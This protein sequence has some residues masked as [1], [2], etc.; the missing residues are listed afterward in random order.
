[1]LLKSKPM[2]T[3]VQKSQVRYFCGY[4][5]LGEQALPANGYRFFTE[6]GEMEYKLINLQPGEEW[7]VI[8]YYIVNL[9]QLK[10]DIPTVRNNVDTKQAAVWYWNTNELRDRRRLFNYVRR[11][12]CNF[13]GLTPGPGLMTGAIGFMV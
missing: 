12:L 13:L 1:M 5:A 8:N 10:S 3:E 2:L 7:E 6:Y 11:E 4:G 9:S